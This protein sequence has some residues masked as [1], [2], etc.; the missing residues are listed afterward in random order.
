MKRDSQANLLE[1][2]EQG[3]LDPTSDL[4]SLLR[5]CITLGGRTGSERLRTWATLELK[6]YNEGDELPPYRYITAPLQMD[7]LSATGIMKGQAVPA[8]LIPDFAH[9]YLTGNI[10][11]PEAIAEIAEV[12][13][14]A[15]KRGDDSVRIGPKGGHLL[16]EAMNSEL[17]QQ[18]GA[19]Q[20]IDR[21]YWSVSLSPIARILD[22]VRTNLVELVAEMRAGTPGTDLP[23]RQTT[24]QAVDVAIY[25]R[26]NRVVINQAGPHSEVTAAAGGTATAHA[27]TSETPSRKVMWWLVAVA[28]IV[29]AVAGVWALFLAR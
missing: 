6:G 4:P 26:R 8:S 9:D 18:G 23:S 29:A 21:I 25:G 7:V 10:A 24:E 3:A 14:S 16:V 2:I 28:T 27:G 11:F 1:E 5:S 19:S 22:I 20:L 13:S 12:L 17:A 15:R